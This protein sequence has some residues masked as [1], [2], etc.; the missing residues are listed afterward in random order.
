MSLYKPAILLESTRGSLCEREHYGFVLVVDKDGNVLKKVGNSDNREFYLRSCEKPFQALPLLL[1]GAYKKLS[2]QH[3]AVCCA[4][5][6]G[7]ISHT[8]LVSEILNK[9][10]L[11][12]SFLKCETHPPLDK[13][14]QN[15]LIKN[16]IEPCVLHNNCSGKH[17]G[18]LAACV[19]NKWDLDNYLDISHPIQKQIL[20]KIKDYCL[21]DSELPVTL[22]GCMTPVVG[23]SLAKMGEGFINLFLENSV[24][25]QAFL[26]NPFLIG[27]M[28]RL[29]SHIVKGSN[30]KLIS[31]V[32]AEG[33]CVVVNID[34]KQSLI[35]KVLDADLKARSIITIESLKQLNWLSEEEMNS[36]E[37]G[38]V[39]DREVKTNTG[40]VI[41]ELKTPFCL[42]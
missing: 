9:F 23:M 37:I 17:A 22:D 1:S 30:S 7:T 36:I 20:E 40:K 12:D 28:G 42:V 25:Q 19:E 39:N 3:I 29:D 38:Q 26:E 8:Q 16:G 10:G 13:D 14:T 21:I 34:K 35:V 4:S 32:G 27:G 31:K 24:L 15:T 18:L 5:H 41:G 6:T 33:L 11:S 2:T